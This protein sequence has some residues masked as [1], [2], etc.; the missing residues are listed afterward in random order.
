MKISETL[1][2]TTRQ[3]DFPS[4][5]GGEEFV[6]LLPETDHDSALLAGEKILRE[7]RSSVFS[8][9]NGYF[10]LTVSI[11]ISSTSIHTY[12]DANQ[13]IEDADRALYT[14]KHKGKDRV[15]VFWPGKPHGERHLV[16]H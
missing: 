11:D 15:E 5:F 7:I 6:L 14:A 13:M 8:A 9:N 4:R 2:T 10:S 16:A 1:R 12:S 3:S